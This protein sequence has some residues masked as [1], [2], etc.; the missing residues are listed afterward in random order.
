[1]IAGKL[2]YC[3]QS[4]HRTINAYLLH[5]QSMW[6]PFAGT[7]VV[8]ALIA[9]QVVYILVAAGVC[10]HPAHR[11]CVHVCTCVHVHTDRQASQW[12][13]LYSVTHWCGLQGGL[14][15]H[16]TNHRHML[17][18]GIWMSAASIVSGG[19]V[20][21]PSWMQWL[22]DTSGLGGPW[23]GHP[24]NCCPAKEMYVLRTPSFCLH[25]VHS[26]CQHVPVTVTLLLR[27]C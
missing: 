6:W 4:W 22:V 19:T 9:V 20:C 15:A 26:T 27:A 10:V 12:Q 21:R 1:M 16:I 17:P 7:Q 13:R 14:C 5:A 25:P 23:G 24:T 3:C 2:A 8:C 18:I 11:A